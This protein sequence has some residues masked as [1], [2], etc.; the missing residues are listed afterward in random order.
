MKKQWFAV[1]LFLF[2]LL[3]LPAVIVRA[4]SLPKLSSTEL[5]IAAGKSQKLTVE[6]AED[7]SIL[8][9]SSDEQVATV[10]SSGKVTGIQGGQAVI[11]AHVNGQD[12]QCQVTVKS[13]QMQTSTLLMQIKTSNTLKLNQQN[14]SSSITWKSSDKKIAAVSS[15]G[16]VTAK[17]TGTVTITAKADGCTASC[18]ITVV[19]AALNATQ[20][21]L[22]KGKTKLLQITGTSQTAAWKSSKPSVVSVSKK[23]KLTAKKKGTATITAVIDSSITLTCQV[24][25]TYP[26]WNK[27]MDQYQS[28]SNVNQLLF[29]KYT[30]GSSAKVLLYQKSGTKWK[31]LLTCA[32]YVGSNGIGTAK[33]GVSI[34]PTGTYTLTSGFGI[35]PDPGAKMTYLQVNSNHYWCGDRN[36]YNQLIDITQKPHTCAGEH[37]IDYAPSYNYGM[38]FDY[39]KECVYGK[40]SAFFLHCS[41]NYTYTGGCIAVSQQNM[42]KILQ[43]TEKGA[44]ICIYKKDTP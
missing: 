17:K 21:S 24:T 15:K 14:I 6:N 28:D 36:Y 13:I 39:N 16:K 7:S 33:E 40:G 44:K 29:V 9:S 5:S 4:E 22:L 12:L 30:G 42:I 1:W 19:N 25:V 37:L 11:T 20:L 34:T 35:L 26:V 18:K 43:N 31:K 8:W 23:G 38:F 27:L 41:G 10:T 2:G 32:G 3:F